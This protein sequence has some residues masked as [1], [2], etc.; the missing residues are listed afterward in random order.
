MRVD[1]V[2]FVVARISV[3]APDGLVV[4]AVEVSVALELFDQVNAHLLLAV[5]ERTK[6]TVLALPVL[7]ETLAVFGLVLVRVIEFFHPRVAVNTGL[8]LGTLFF[9]RDEAAKFRCVLRWWPTSVLQLLMKVGTPLQVVP[10][11]VDVLAFDCFEGLKIE[12]HDVVGSLFD[13]ASAQER[14][15]RCVNT[16]RRRRLTA[17]CWY[18]LGVVVLLKGWVGGRLELLVRF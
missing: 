17:L 10:L 14:Y 7:E 6:L 8:A 13:C 11:L 16:E 15:L 18:F 3:G 1:T 9:L 12:S 5:R 2:I 4:K